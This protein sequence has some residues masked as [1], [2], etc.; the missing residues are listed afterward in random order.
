MNSVIRSR[1]VFSRWLISTSLSLV[2]M[3]SPACHGQSATKFRAEARTRSNGAALKMPLGT[4]IDLV[5]TGYNYTDRDIDQ[6]YVDGQGGGNISESGPGDAGSGSVCC[7]SFRSGAKARV[8]KV[9]WQADACIFTN[10]TDDEGQKH[11]RTHSYFKEVD[12]QVDPIIPD[13][14]RYLEIHFYPDGHLE[15]AI[16]EHASLARLVLSKDRANNSHFLRCP[17]DIEP[18]A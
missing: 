3:V 10:Y 8:V 7:I 9:R 16:T 2:M 1:P 18:K 11:E 13:F 4:Q 5:L 6:F 14:P 15:A 12:V 17:N